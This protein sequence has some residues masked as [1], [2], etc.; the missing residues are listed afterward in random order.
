MLLLLLLN[1]L[2]Y[3]ITVLPIFL[4]CSP[5]PIP[6]PLPYCFY[7]LNTLIKRLSHCSNDKIILS[8][9]IT[10][11][12]TNSNTYKAVMGTDIYRFKADYFHFCKYR[13]EQKWVNNTYYNK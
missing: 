7:I 2:F 4:P 9:P 3:A 8:L 5:P 13:S 11:N 10:N 12:N 1:I 6:H